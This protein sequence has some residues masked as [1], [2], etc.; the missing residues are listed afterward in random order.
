MTFSAGFHVQTWSAVDSWSR[1][2]LWG[3]TLNAALWISVLRR[4]RRLEEEMIVSL[5]V[6]HA[7]FTEW[8]ISQTDWCVAWRD[9]NGA[10]CWHHC[11]VI[12]L[13]ILLPVNLPQSAEFMFLPA[14]FLQTP[15]G[16]FVC[17]FGYKIS[18]FIAL[19]VQTRKCVSRLEK[20]GLSDTEAE[21]WW[22]KTHSLFFHQQKARNAVFE[23]LNCAVL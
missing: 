1:L 16:V 17:F 7:L 2:K 21:Y 3:G 19:C 6:N 23:L 11:S 13:E 18:L 22:A 4:C 8:I 9:E 14:R 15:P 10:L 12:T 5:R 20:V